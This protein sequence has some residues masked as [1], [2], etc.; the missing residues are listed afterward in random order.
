MQRIEKTQ[1]KAEKILKN[2]KKE[3]EILTEL[4]NSSNKDFKK[5]KDILKEISEEL[6]EFEESIETKE[7]LNYIDLNSEEDMKIKKKIT[8]KNKKKSKSFS[9]WIFNNKEL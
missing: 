3:L 8:I 4:N 1:D 9:N 6:K 7:N 2:I 5:I